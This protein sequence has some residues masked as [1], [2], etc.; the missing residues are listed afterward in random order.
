MTNIINDCIIYLTRQSEGECTSPDPAK[1]TTNYESSRPNFTRAQDGYF[2]FFIFRMATIND[3]V[4]KIIINSSY[5][6]ISIIL[7]V[8][9]G[10]DES[11]S[12]NYLVKYIKFEFSALMLNTSRRFKLV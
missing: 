12:P 4:V 2:L 1:L 8:R 6:L 11:T 9:L 7:S 5:V 3:A 10:A